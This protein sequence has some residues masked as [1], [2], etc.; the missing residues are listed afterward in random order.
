MPEEKQKQDALGKVPL[1]FFGAW[2]L[3]KF[4]NDLRKKQEFAIF[5][6]WDCGY[7][8]RQKGIPICPNCGVSLYWGNPSTDKAPRKVKPPISPMISFIVFCVTFIVILACLLFIDIKS[9]E[10]FETI[11]VICPMSFGYSI[12]QR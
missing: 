1:F 11:K 7:T 2:L 10:A 5:K 3:G 12:G 6:C 9:P 8:L 4:L